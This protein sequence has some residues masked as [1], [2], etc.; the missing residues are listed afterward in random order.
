MRSAARISN[1]DRLHPLAWG[2]VS[3]NATLRPVDG[4]SETVMTPT[5]GRFALRCLCASRVPA[6]WCVVCCIGREDLHRRAER[7]VM[8]CARDQHEFGKPFVIRG[9]F[10]H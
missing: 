7:A 1:G 10:Q 8:H 2:Q 6:V 3:Q 5:H 9:V 4:F